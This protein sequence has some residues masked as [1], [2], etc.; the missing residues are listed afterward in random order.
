MSCPSKCK[1]P[2]CKRRRQAAYRRS[3][4]K[5]RARGIPESAH[6]TNAGYA[7]YGCRQPCCKEAHATTARKTAA[8]KKQRRLE[9]VVERLKSRA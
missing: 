8:R 9:A 2:T 7:Y 3:R 4:A 5:A 6:G 1:C